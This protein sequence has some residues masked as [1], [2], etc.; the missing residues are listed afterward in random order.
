[1]LN[2][3]NDIFENI[4]KIKVS[5]LVQVAKVTQDMAYKMKNSRALPSLEKAVL[6]E[7]ELD[8][9]ARVWVDM[10]NK[11]EVIK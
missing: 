2:M 7:D 4:Q 9:P 10:K 5:Q 11:K 3:K 6:I 8:I 1:M